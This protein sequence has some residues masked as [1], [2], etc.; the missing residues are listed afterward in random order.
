MLIVHTNSTSIWLPHWDSNPPARPTVNHKHNPPIAQLD[1][2]L[3]PSNR[4]IHTRPTFVCCPGC[5]KVYTRALPADFCHSHQSWC[6]GGAHKRTHTHT[7][8]WV[9]W[10]IPLVAVARLSSPSL[11]LTWTQACTHEYCA[12]LKM[13]LVDVILAKTSKRSS[14]SYLWQQFKFFP[15]C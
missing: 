7:F 2:T 10:R 13:L 9:C 11:E 6:N 5:A 8:A 14:T 12:Y 15:F 4:H 3:P 1:C